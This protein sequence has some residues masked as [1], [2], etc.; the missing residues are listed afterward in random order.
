MEAVARALRLLEPEGKDEEL[1]EGEAM[2][3]WLRAM[4]DFGQ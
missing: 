3:G 2:L 1:E 4:V